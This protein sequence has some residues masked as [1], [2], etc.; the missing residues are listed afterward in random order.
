MDG[1]KQRGNWTKHESTLPKVAMELVFIT[2]VMDA[3]EGR[4]VVC[5]NIPGAFLHADSDKGITMILKGR[6]AELMEQVTPNLYRK[7]I[8]V[9]RKGMTILCAKMQKAMYGLLG[10]ALLFHSNLVVDVENAG[11]TLNQ[12]NPCVA[13]K[14]V[15]NTQ[16]IVCWRVDAFESLSRRSARDHKVQ[17]LAKRNLQSVCGNPSRKSA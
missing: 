2:A 13:N 5:F 17:G 4:D 11:F 8:T 1:S 12:Y 3:H 6:L 16:M 14:T 15:N 9:D 10:S 7:Y